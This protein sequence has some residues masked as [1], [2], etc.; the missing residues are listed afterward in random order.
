MR[1]FIKQRN[2]VRTASSEKSVTNHVRDE[3]KNQECQDDG[4]QE[5]SDT[6]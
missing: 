6:E 3:Q 2:R 4:T 5:T 1:I